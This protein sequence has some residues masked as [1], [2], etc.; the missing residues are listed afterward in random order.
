MRRKRN[1]KREIAPDPKYSNV[2][3]A[4]FINYVMKGGKKSTAEKIVY[5][6]F[7]RI[8]EKYKQ[9]P[10]QVFDLALKNVGPTLEVRS[11]RIGGASYQVPREVRGER[12]LALTYRWILGAARSKK[13][14]AMYEKL[15]DELMAASKNEGEAIKKRNDTHRMA[16]SNRA[17]AHFSW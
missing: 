5:K 7:D 10:L 4:K 1:I 15:A 2:L 13:G 17:F 16:D 11:R 14:R 9:D 12:K 6:T 8:E 3:I